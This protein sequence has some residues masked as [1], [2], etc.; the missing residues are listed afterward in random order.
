MTCEVAIMNRRA[1]VLA[2]DSALTASTWVDGK[3]E[4]RY[5]KG[6][7]KIF[8][9]S[10]YHP[11][12]LMTYDNADLQKVPWE[13][14]IK[15][16]RAGLG[17]KSF[18]SIEDYGNDLFDFIRK[19]VDILP[20]EERDAYFHDKVREVTFHQIYHVLNSDVFKA[21]TTDDARQ[22]AAA[23]VIDGAREQVSKKPFF[24]AFEES[25]FENAW[26]AHEHKLKE[27]AARILEFLEVNS[28]IE[29]NS[30]ARLAAESL[31]KNVEEHLPAT[32]IVVAGYGDKGFFPSLQ[33]YK[34]YG[35]F[36]GK[37]LSEKGESRT[38]RT[39]QSS[40]I[41]GFEL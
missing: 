24:S 14:I 20:I 4:T 7:N 29:C 35:A 13:L 33:E 5:F 17:D 1:V 18:N 15:A 37:V 36:L 34:C 40:E 41:V 39:D 25:D 38:I 28:F 30:I 12:G 16:Y 32:G 9:S 22:A 21:A 31:L 11:V 23:E 10:E 27:D 26:S 3:S 8:H 19:N 6:S 2:A